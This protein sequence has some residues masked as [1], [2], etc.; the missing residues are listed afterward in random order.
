MG[1]MNLVETRQAHFSKLRYFINERKKIM[2]C[3]LSV[4][5]IRAYIFFLQLSWKHKVRVENC[6][7]F[8]QPTIYSACGLIASLHADF[9][10]KNVVHA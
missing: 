8:S 9:K 4:T 6:C 3:T 10:R 2:F 1:L 7:D 5:L